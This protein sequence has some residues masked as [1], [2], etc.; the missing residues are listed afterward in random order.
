MVDLNI[1]IINENQEEIGSLTIYQD[2]SDAEATTRILQWI[3]EE[4]EV[5]HAEGVSSPLPINIRVEEEDQ[6]RPRYRIVN[7]EEMRE[8][9]ERAEVFMKELNPAN[10]FRDTKSTTLCSIVEFLAN[11]IGATIYESA[12]GS[13]IHKRSIR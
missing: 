10:M 11:D 7:D 5:D 2:G 6:A 9:R 3:A 8:F 13:H 1:I 4:Y 12:V